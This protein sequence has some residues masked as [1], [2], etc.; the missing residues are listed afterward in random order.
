M[1]FLRSLYDNSIDS[2][3]FS[4][5]GFAKNNSHAAP[6]VISKA[7]ISPANVAKC[8]RCCGGGFFIS[9]YS[10]RP[11]SFVMLNGCELLFNRSTILNPD[12]MAWG[13][14]M[15]DQRIGD[16]LPDDYEYK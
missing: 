9:Y 12:D 7:S 3:G 14:E 15:A 11:S 2:S 6:I 4:I 5:E 13:G 1:H 8:L 10:K 16:L